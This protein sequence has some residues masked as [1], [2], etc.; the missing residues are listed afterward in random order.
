MLGNRRIQLNLVDRGAVSMAVYYRGLLGALEQLQDF[1]LIYVHD[2]T[3]FIGDRALTLLPRLVCECVPLI[4]RF[5]QKFS[6]PVRVSD[7]LSEFHVF[8]IVDA[9][10]ISVQQHHR[11][12]FTAQ[13]VGI[14]D[15][16]CTALFCLVGAD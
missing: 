7:L 1:I 16:S 12:G 8:G 4:E 15:E 9:E 13:Y 5:R 3:G 10:L 6:L 11:T 2:L 14:F